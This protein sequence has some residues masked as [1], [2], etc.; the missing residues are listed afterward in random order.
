[1]T[2]MISNIASEIN[3]ARFRVESL[4]HGTGKAAVC[5]Y[6][7]AALIL[8]STVF[9]TYAAAQSERGSIGGQIQSEGRSLNEQDGGESECDTIAALRL[10]F[11]ST[12]D[13]H[14]RKEPDWAR[15]VTVCAAEVQAHPGVMRFIYQLGRSQDHAKNYIEALRNYKTVVDAG[16]TE[17]MVDLGAMYYYGHGVIQNY[18][19]AF[20]YFSKAADAGSNRAVANLAA[21]YGDGLGVPRD[22]AKSLD[23]AEKAVEGG[24]PFGLKIIADHYF[25][26]AG[27]ERNYPMA[28]QYLQQAADLGDGRSMKFLANMYES[29]YL[30]PP[31][32]AKAGELRLQ[33][34]RIDP[35]SSDPIPLHLPMLKKVS[36]DGPYSSAPAQRRRY[37]VYHYN[38]AWQAAPGD[39]RCCPNNMLVCPLGRHFCGH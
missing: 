39:T 4:K 3:A 8:I 11:S 24:N 33:A 31:N 28:A 32:P 35:G 18:H 1:M 29:G 5:M 17:A 27:V 2:E 20:D 36:A 13:V 21:M 26:D 7:I 19:T 10:P 22:A 14:E 38:P 37:V 9:G 23:L 12:T 34:Q 15:G 16:F 30:G 6:T 25:N